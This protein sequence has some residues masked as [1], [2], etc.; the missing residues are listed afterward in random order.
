MKTK[1]LPGRCR[2]HAAVADVQWVVFR[3]QAARKLS[4]HLASADSSA[5]DKVVSF[6]AKH[7]CA[8]ETIGGVR[9]LMK[10]GRNQTWTRLA[11][12]DIH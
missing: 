4:K 11:C 1:Y 9:T 3:M 6:T 8:S 12:N 2:Y 10:R 7:A 5:K